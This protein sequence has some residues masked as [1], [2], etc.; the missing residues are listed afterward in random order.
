[1]TREQRIVEVFVELA[2]SLVG[3]FDV[4]DLL[5][6]L[7]ERCVELL[8]CA[9]AGLL[10][11]D[12]AGVLRVMA[13]SSERTEALELLQ[14]QTADGPCVECFERGE[15]VFSDDLVVDRERWPAFAPAAAEQGFRSVQALPLRVRSDTIGALN[16]FRTE[17]G[18]I[19]EPDLSVGQ[20]MAH[21]AAIALLQERSMRESL[22]VIEQLQAALNSRVVIEQA[23]GMLAERTTTS[24]D[25]AF[26]QLRDYARR[27][28]LRLSDVA[29]E[30]VE[31][32]LDA[33]ALAR[34]ASSSSTG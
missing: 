10:L 20:G 22:G 16:L 32:E 9:E 23:K 8:D 28:N 15:P 7:T 21:I 18:R 1:M 13:S 29:R 24:V 5:H 31:G 27:H 30:L 26:A 4:L 2:D 34:P 6:R 11:A 12:A 25:R 14:S 33:A 3:D 17:L 19:A